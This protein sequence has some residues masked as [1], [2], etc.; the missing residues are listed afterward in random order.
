MTQYI[1]VYVNITDGQKQKL[2]HAIDAGCTMTSLRLGK[3]D[4]QG[5]HKLALT[6]AQ[7]N[8]L[9]KA[10]D[11]G[12]GITI[13]M[14]K[15]QLKYN[16]KVEGGF[17]GLLAG[18]AARALPMAAKNVLPASGVGALSGLASSGVQKAMGNGLYLKK[19]G[20]VCQ[21][22]TD[23]EGLYLKPY[24]GR[25]LNSYGNGLYLKQ[26]GKI[27]DGYGLLLGQNSPFKNIPILG[28]IL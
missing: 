4:L 5:E 11:Q 17:L 12:K 13:R 23:G 8:K 24:K 19:G 26:G 25:G 6:T 27:Y 16:I 22:E 7:I 28:A 9:N 10:I 18:L 3:D 14:S 2:K 21:V 20:C 15:K 1:D